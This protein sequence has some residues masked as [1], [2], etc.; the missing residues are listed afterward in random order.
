M[1]EIFLNTAAIGRISPL[2]AKKMSD[3]VIALSQG[4]PDIRNWVL[5]MERCR[6]KAAELFGVAGP[7]S[8]GFLQNTSQAISTVA[9]GLSWEQGDEIIVPSVEYPANQYPWINLQR[10]GTVL[11]SAEPNQYGGLEWEDFERY[12]TPKTKLISF[13]HVQF[14]NGYRCDIERIARECRSRGII[15][16]VDVIQSAGVFDLHQNKWGVDCMVAGSQKWLQGPPGIGILS[17]SP[18]LISQISPVLTGAFS[19]KNPHDVTEIV[20]DFHDDGHKFESGTMNFLGF[21]GF[22]QALTESLEDSGEVVLLRRDLLRREL[23][24]RG[25]TICGSDKSEKLSGIITFTHSTIDIEALF[26]KLNLLGV[27]ATFRKNSIRL[28]PDR[29]TSIENIHD[30]VEILDRTI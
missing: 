28:A 26:E 11:V 24:Q 20:L 13:S 8:V 10:R 18:D 30:F 23:L 4:A 29:S 3:A 2:A 1:K 21:V 5:S 19:V 16:V 6:R 15:T 14:L 17:I 22:E 9:E 25:M 27:V 7:E 12:I